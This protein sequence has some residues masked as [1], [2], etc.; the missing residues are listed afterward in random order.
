[1]SF[2]SLRSDS[3]NYNNDYY[4]PPFDYSTQSLVVPPDLIGPPGALNAICTV[5][6]VCAGLRCFDYTALT[7][8]GSTC[9][10]DYFTLRAF[11]STSD[12]EKW[13]QCACTRAEGKYNVYNIVSPLGPPNSTE[14]RWITDNVCTGLAYTPW[15]WSVQ[16]Q[17]AASTNCPSASRILTTFALVNIAVGFLGLCFGH[18]K[19]LNKISM[20]LLGKPGSTAWKYTWLIT[21]AMQV[22]ANILIALL[23]RATPGYGHS[24]TIAQL[25]LL[26]FA[27]PRIGCFVALAAAY[28]SISSDSVYD[29]FAF[30]HFMGEIVLQIL[31]APSIGYAAA[32]AAKKGFLLK[33]RLHNK[34]A[35]LMY[36]GAFFWLCASIFVI[37]AALWYIIWRLIF[38]K[39]V[40]TQVDRR[41]R[42]RQPAGSTWANK[43]KTDR[44]KDKTDVPYFVFF[45]GGVMFLTLYIALW[46]FWGG[47]VGLAGETYCPPN[48][49]HQGLIWT[50]FSLVGALVGGGA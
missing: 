37:T 45:L 1:M 11:N 32:L 10:N 35:K 43:D 3:Y 50:G 6:S 19:V 22:G 42:R 12:S 17:D 24:F 9:G 33:G 40:E 31:A 34:Y 26:L 5:G 39:K 46:L 49:A 18:R 14:Q 27:R 41:P 2:L 47:F 44:P 25:T 4:A 8:F 23:I 36:G 16:P 13:A 20:G 15:T 29:S 21:V 38:L 30:T 7:C 28:P 48:L